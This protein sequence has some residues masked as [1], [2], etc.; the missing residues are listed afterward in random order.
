MV[1]LPVACITAQPTRVATSLALASWMVGSDRPP[2]WRR[3]GTGLNGLEGTEGSGFIAANL[4]PLARSGE[5]WLPGLAEYWPTAASRPLL[6]WLSLDCCQFDSCARGN[7]G[8]RIVNR[9]TT[10]SSASTSMCRQRTDRRLR[11]PFRHHQG[12]TRAMPPSRRTD[13]PRQ[14]TV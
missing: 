1:G 5:L 3:T 7:Q 8:S 2:A 9:S 14:Y 6:H 13:G 10:S 4:C 11:S 12:R